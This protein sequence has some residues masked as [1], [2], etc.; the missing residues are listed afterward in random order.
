MH[1]KY[2]FLPKE[3]MVHKLLSSCNLTYTSS[4]AVFPWGWW[5]YPVI[6]MSLPTAYSYLYLN[7]SRLVCHGH[8][9]WHT[10]T[11]PEVQCF[12]VQVPG[13]IPEKGLH[14]WSSVSHWSGW[15][16]A[17][18]WYWVDNVHQMLW[19]EDFRFSFLKEQSR[20]TTFMSSS[21]CNRVTPASVQKLC[22]EA[23]HFATLLYFFILPSC[24]LRQNYYIVVKCLLVE[25]CF[26]L[27][28]NHSLTWI[29]AHKIEG[30]WDAL[31]LHLAS[32]P[33]AKDHRQEWDSFINLFSLPQLIQAVATSYS[34]IRTC[35]LIYSSLL[36]MNVLFIYFFSYKYII[37]CK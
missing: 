21:S 4:P 5:Y 29:L 34:Y 26:I 24:P 23:L 33:D 2:K 35:T 12:Q 19:P 28:F 17:K 15:P 22:Q 7:I 6:L 18:M 10:A 37:W 32:F 30:T 11:D 8:F 25:E 31:Q 3:K 13:L 36:P 20:T 27:L 1:T 14:V 16:E 9:P